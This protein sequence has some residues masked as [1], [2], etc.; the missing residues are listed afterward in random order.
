[1]TLVAGAS[2]FLTQATL[3]NSQGSV[4]DSGNVLTYSASSSLLDVGR[5]NSFSG[6][7]LSSRARALNNQLLNQLYLP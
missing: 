5:G 7:G 6:T 2:R 1:M 3:A 4:F